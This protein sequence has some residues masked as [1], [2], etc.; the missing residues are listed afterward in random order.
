MIEI[1]AINY[2]GRPTTTEL[3]GVFGPEGGTLGRGPDNRLSLPDPARHVSRVQASIRFDGS[4]FLI[5]NVSAAN[6][7]FVN[8]EEIES[9][10]ERVIA[11]GDRLRVGLY[12]LVVREAT[13]AP[14]AATKPISELD[15]IASAPL[16]MPGVA[17]SGLDPLLGLSGGAAGLNPFADLLGGAAPSPGPG[18]APSRPASPAPMPS[19]PA[20][21][22]SSAPL[23]GDPFADL[24]QPA[25][26]SAARPPSSGA[27]S[28]PGVLSGDPFADLMQPAAGGAA[29]APSSGAALPSAKPTFTG[30]IPDDFD[31]FS[32]PSK[33]PRNSDDP[34]RDLSG[35][36]VGLNAVGAGD[37][38]SA[39]LEFDLA[40]KADPKDLL[41]GGTPSLVDPL[42]AVDP[43][44]L[45]GGPDDG[46]LHGKADPLA[47]GPAMRDN[48]PELGANFRPPRSL[49]EAPAPAPKVAPASLSSPLAASQ[50]ATSR[51][52]PLSEIPSSLLQET[53]VPEFRRKERREP[54]PAVPPQAQPSAPPPPL[55]PPPKAASSPAQGAAPTEPELEVTYM[56]PKSS[57]PAPA[58]SAKLPPNAPA[59]P[60]NAPA[61][62]PRAQAPAASP[63]AK[64]TSAAPV[65]R[66]ADTD[67][68]LAAFLKG[69]GVPNMAV[70]NG[71]TPEMMETM[72]A[73]VYRA[74]AGAMELIAARQITKREIRAEVTMIVAQGNNPL[75][76]LPT[77][78]A[79]IMQMLGPKMPGFM[80]TSEAMQDAFDDLAAHEVGVI[81]GMR[82]ALAAV[83]KRFDPAVLEQRLGKGGLLDSLVPNAREGKLW[84]LFSERFQEIFREAED[85]FQAL[86]G[87][88][89]I[90]AYEEQV[91]RDRAK[92]KRG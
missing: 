19:P 34:L 9:G 67:A 88:A 90:E 45:F 26:R 57:R 4:R 70:P 1:Q 47:G 48:L 3:R 69:A 81:A 29:R 63:A 12:Q 68:L 84:N 56:A 15:T 2:K 23:S 55:P 8:E 72:G 38:K 28:A 24:M 64:P 5:S 92:R 33:A 49:P 21:R 32:M 42:T 44:D 50:P 89:F 91:A 35:A 18:G 37:A 61:S 31:V 54:L 58:A 86:F 87:K 40:K 74:T 53:V 20:A 36:S 41:Q 78:E 66:T 25:A 39:M 73:L 65:A 43:L 46:L 7:L 62:P 59:S 30:G 60:P 51:G 11:P 82:A 76:F 71:L 13:G 52:V 75:K 17:P 77:P 6:P 79:A 16:P 14:P 10:V 80:R 85:D 27:A 83:L 22:P